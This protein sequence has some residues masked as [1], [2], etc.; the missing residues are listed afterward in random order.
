MI[1]KLL[2]V[3]VAA[4][5][6]SAHAAWHEARSNHFIVYSDDDAADVAR[7]A[8]RLER[9]DRVLRFL[10]KVPNTPIAPANRVTVY[11]TGDTSSI[12]RLSGSSNVAGFYIPRAGGSV[13]FV[14]KRTGEGIDGEEVL[15]HEYTHHFMLSNW[16][17]TAFPAWYVEGF[18][19]F[20]ATTRMRADGTIEIARPPMYRIGSFANG[21]PVSARELL[22]SAPS[23]ID[24]QG[25]YAGGWLL[26][27]MLLLD[28]ARR[29]QLDRFMG[30]MAAGTPAEQAATQALGDLRQ[31]DRDMGRYV[32]TGL[33]YSILP[34]SAIPPAKVEVRALTPAEA[35]TMAVRI[36]SK[37]GV[38]RAAA[39]AL[40][41]A[42]RRAAAPY[43]ND[44]AAQ[45]VLAE[46]EYDA[47]NYAAAEGAARRAVAADPKSVDGHVYIGMAQ[48]AQARAARDTDPEHWRAIRRSFIAANKLENDDPEPL[49]L[50][51]QS[52]LD[53]GQT[54]NANARDALLR[55]H[56]LGPQ[57]RGLRM[58]AARVLLETDRAADARRVLG[59]VAYAPH[60]GP[61]AIFAAD[62]IAAID[63][64]GTKAALQRWDAS[65]KEQR[66][67][68]GDAG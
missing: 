17:D 41:P 37:R 27:H 5:P 61:S 8:E 12:A 46:A 68:D 38:D 13:A 57:D 50:F 52:Y 44:P 58:Q 47:G 65:S 2:A 42:A 7:F 9:F 67:E 26:T 29:G 28:P 40:L 15:F 20:F 21:L 25:L 16:S 49:M 11:V 59:P 39:L 10:T 1:R 55:A 53:N 54:P 56:T 30:A 64:G 24:A 43:P 45:V 51:Y 31:L 3:L 19:E 62:L 34:A 14:P 32:R 66:G 4:M 23:K 48:M 63:G 22:T 36:R 6:V 33:R 60:G 35:A 18:A